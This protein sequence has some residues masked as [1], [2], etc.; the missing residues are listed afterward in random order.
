MLASHQFL[1]APIHEYA[2]LGDLKA[3][4]RVL[5]KNNVDILDSDENTPLH[6]AAQYG[7]EEVAEY[8]LK[9]QANVNAADKFDTTP[10]HK[11]V[12]SGNEKMV[13][14]LIV[15]G[16]DIGKE[17]RGHNSP[18]IIAFMNK[19]FSIAQTLTFFDKGSALMSRIVEVIK[20]PKLSCRAVALLKFLTKRYKYPLDMKDSQGKN[21]LYYATAY[22]H[23]PALKLLLASDTNPSS[24]I[25]IGGEKYSSVVATFIHADDA[26]GIL[27]IFLDAAYIK[28][29]KQSD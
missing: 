5:K 26:L 24:S 15:S 2:K 17:D 12:A 14:L 22:N 25:V 8:L 7:Q 9:L 27:K 10:L 18:L 28:D 21:L 11:A 19:H 13:S 1:A 6:Y 4:K 20:N 23:K 3:L 16:A 29:S